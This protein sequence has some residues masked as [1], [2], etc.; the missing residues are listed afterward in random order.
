MVL[1]VVVAAVALVVG[2]NMAW[3]AASDLPVSEIARG[4]EEAARRIGR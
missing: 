4:A 1:G 2:I 3:K